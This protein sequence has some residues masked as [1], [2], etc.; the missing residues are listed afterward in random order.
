LL[1]LVGSQRALELAVRNVN[2]TPRSTALAA[3]LGGKGTV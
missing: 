3:R 2:Q 1:V